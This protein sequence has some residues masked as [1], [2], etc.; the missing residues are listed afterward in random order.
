VFLTD[1]LCILVYLCSPRCGHVTN[2]HTYCCQPQH[3]VSVRSTHATCFR[4]T[5]GPWAFQHVIFNCIYTEFVRCHE[6]HTEFVRC[7]ELYTE[8][9]R[10][11]E[12]YKYIQ[13]YVENNIYRYSYISRLCFSAELLAAFTNYKHKKQVLS[14]KRNDIICTHR[15][16]YQ[17]N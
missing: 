15:E 4:P 13:F 17:A 10:C 5:D 14:I 6:L 3:P 12:L 9:V 16:Y 7:H 8:F 2:W 11:H 1:T